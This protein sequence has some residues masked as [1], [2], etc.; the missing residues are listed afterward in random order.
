MLYSILEFPTA[1]AL[2]YCGRFNLRIFF[3]N[4][5]T[6]FFASAR[7]RAHIPRRA[8]F[9][10]NNSKNTVATL[11]TSVNSKMIQNETK[12]RRRFQLSPINH[13]VFNR[14]S[15]I[16]PVDLPSAIKNV[17]ESD[18]RQMMTRGRTSNQFHSTAALYQ[19]HQMNFS[20]VSS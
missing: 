16:W 6:F 18:I 17:Y 5:C 7:F 11:F 1:Y 13:S 14:I 20:S 12:F 4:R 9:L 8:Q 3:A 10:S 15:H 2:L 19:L